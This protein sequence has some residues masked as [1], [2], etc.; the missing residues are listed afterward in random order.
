MLQVEHPANTSH[1][2]QSQ[3][4][5]HE[6]PFAVGGNKAVRIT[7]LLA[8][9]RGWL[10]RRFV[11]FAGCGSRRLSA[12]LYP[13]LPDMAPMPHTCTPGT[14]GWTLIGRRRVL[15]GR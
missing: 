14:R 13:I 5:E 11:A 10:F 6:R 8:L 15:I 1:Y 12:C 3:Q 9:G 7:F 2:E 4:G